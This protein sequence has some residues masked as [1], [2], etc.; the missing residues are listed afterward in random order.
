MGAFAKIADALMPDW[1]AKMDDQTSRLRQHVPLA[2]DEAHSAAAAKL[3]QLQQL[4]QMLGYNMRSEQRDR[5]GVGQILGNGA[6]RERMISL[7]AQSPAPVPAIGKMALLGSITGPLRNALEDAKLEVQNIADEKRRS[8]TR[9]TSDPMTIP[10]FAPSVA[11]TVPK[12]FAHGY[13]TAD[14]EMDA[15]AKADMEAQIAA[16]RG[17]FESALAS[18]YG[19][20]HK[21]ANFG[22]L[23][24]GLAKV[25]CLTKGADGELNRALG[26]Y[27]A[28]AALLGQGAHVTA[29]NWVEG[30]DPRHQKA[31]ALRNA[32]RMKQQANPPPVLV[33]PPIA[34]MQVAE[35]PLATEKMAVLE[36]ALP[37]L[38]AART[39]L[40]PLDGPTI[41]NGLKSIHTATQLGP[42]YWANKLKAAPGQLMRHANVGLRKL[43]KGL[44]ISGVGRTFDP[45][46]D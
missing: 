13:R 7:P 25:A 14:S 23:L 3:E 17:E 1:R 35:D 2:A 27:L 32:I 38:D 29:K 40:M 26:M 18:E 12:S 43:D 45:N 36:Q 6:G 39:A 28:G 5:Q 11:L 37:I 15:A 46:V 41:I 24:D 10:T 31:K 34:E 9:I 8:A 19:G 21:M 30:H 20:G 42:S 4:A 22:E 44:N 16:A 33:A